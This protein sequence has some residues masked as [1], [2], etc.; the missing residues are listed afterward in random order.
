MTV[1]F[2]F[3]ATPVPTLTASTTTPEGKV[4]FAGAAA[5]DEA[6]AKTKVAAKKERFMQLFLF[7]LA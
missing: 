3:G 4:C 1:S 6:A 7:A 5:L 2:A